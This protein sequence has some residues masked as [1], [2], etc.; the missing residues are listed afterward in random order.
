M[1]R[2]ALLLVGLLLVAGCGAEA[3]PASDPSS[4]AVAVG[5]SAA[6]PVDVAAARTVSDLFVRSVD[7]VRA[8]AF[9]PT[10]S[11]ALVDAEGV[12]WTGTSVTRE[13]SAAAAWSAASPESRYGVESVSKGLTALALLSLLREV[14]PE[15]DR[16]LD[17]DCG[18]LLP[19]ACRAAGV[20]FRDVLCHHVTCREQNTAAHGL[21]PSCDYAQAAA[22]EAGVAA[23]RVLPRGTATP[24][25]DYGN[26][27]YSLAGW[28]LAHPALQPTPPSAPAESTYAEIARQL[29]ARV[30]EPV[31]MKRTALMY[32]A[33]AVADTLPAA[34]WAGSGF[35]TLRPP[36][37][38]DLAARGVLSTA[39]DLGRLLVALLADGRLDGQ[40]ALASEVVQQIRIVSFGQPLE[41]AQIAASAYTAG[42]RRFTSPARGIDLLWKDGWAGETGTAS[43]V[44][45]D[46]TRRLGFCAITNTWGAADDVHLSLASGGHTDVKQ[47]DEEG[48]VVLALLR[49]LAEVGFDSLTEPGSPAPPLPEAAARTRW[50]GFYRGPDGQR[51]AQVYEH[52]HEGGALSLVFEEGRRAGVLVPVEPAAGAGGPA[53][54]AQLAFDQPAE[55]LTFVSGAAPAQDALL[56]EADGLPA[57]RWTREPQPSPKELAELS[58]LAAAVE[59][60]WEGPLLRA[61]ERGAGP[62]DPLRIT[63]GS[64]GADVS[65]VS[66]GQFL[67]G[68]PAS[69][70]ALRPGAHGF[71]LRVARHPLYGA[72]RLRLELAADGK[73]LQAEWLQGTERRTAVLGR[74]PPRPSPGNLPPPRLPALRGTLWARGTSRAVEILPVPPSGGSPGS[75]PAGYLLRVD[76]PGGASAPLLKLTWQDDREQV[77][78]RVQ[79]PSI[80]WSEFH[81]RLDAQGLR[82]TARGTGVPR[83]DGVLELQRGP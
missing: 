14:Q 29:A 67:Q 38:Q 80:P 43:L 72:I 24:I 26:R 20:T 8:F 7:V 69:Y 10:L 64:A 53:F 17:S 15:R 46:L 68:E 41:H 59:G 76:G 23:I 82:G 2:R 5:T 16:D 36:C 58:D 78:F 83:S 19:P 30:F 35:E 12:R 3:P 11:V 39:D 73:R 22:Y 71:E 48:H 63:F 57:E 1:R 81:A 25:C 74:V 65:L 60:E 27:P 9:L 47:V 55:R 52:E 77:S 42:W 44:I 31:G 51:V 79:H 45:L 18:D 49:A 40:Q 13:G 54:R 6:G 61:P 34:Q 33:Q 28:L 4:G 50:L 32:D 70:A 66:P 62:S 21:L 56:R 37:H 75:A